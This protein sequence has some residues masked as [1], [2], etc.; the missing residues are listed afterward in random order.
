MILAADKYWDALFS[1][2]CSMCSNLDEQFVR[3]IF[4]LAWTTSQHFSFHHLMLR[5]DDKGITAWTYEVQQKSC[6]CFISLFLCSLF[7]R[8]S[9]ILG[10]DGAK[11]TKDVDTGMPQTLW[12][13][14]ECFCQCYNKY[15]GCWQPVK[16]KKEKGRIFC[17]GSWWRSETTASQCENA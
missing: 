11:A 13:H 14:W 1:T 3:W 12:N 6:T 9:H 8:W 17:N 16:E 7:M 2:N 10:C 4:F 15:I 5:N